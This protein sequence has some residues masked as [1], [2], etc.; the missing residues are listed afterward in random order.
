MSR[1]FFYILI[2]LSIV[3]SV[4]I[5]ANNFEKKEPVYFSPWAGE[6]TIGPNQIAVAQTGYASCSKGLE[7]D[8]IDHTII[9]LELYQDDE[10]LQT[11][12]GEEGEWIWRDY[13]VWPDPTIQ[14]LHLV[15]EQQRATW[16]FKD[17]QLNKPGIYKLRFYKEQTAQMIDG[18]DFDQDGLP[19][20]YPA[21]VLADTIVTIHVLKK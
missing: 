7:Q 6:I 15:D 16:N 18:Y 14:C 1:K 4:L 10:L 19:D 9:T 5:A 8:W 12:S 2:A 20:V 11:V 13:Y 17:L 21:T 3:A